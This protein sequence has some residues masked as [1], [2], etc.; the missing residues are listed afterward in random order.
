MKYKMPLDHPLKEN[1]R[2]RIQEYA[3]NSLIQ[4]LGKDF[5][6]IVSFDGEAIDKPAVFSLITTSL[7]L[8]T[9]VSTSLF[10]I[11]R[12]ELHPDHFNLDVFM[13]KYGHPTI[14]QLI[15]DIKRELEK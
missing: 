6:V 13:N 10:E 15:L 14:N 2:L 11:D 3:Q 1:M 9:I 7:D 8:D 12:D 5:G 4:I